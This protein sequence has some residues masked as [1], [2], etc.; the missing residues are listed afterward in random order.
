[1]FQIWRKKRFDR[2]ARSRIAVRR[3]AQIHFPKL[4]R[5]ARCV[6]GRSFRILR[7]ARFGR[8]CLGRPY[9]PKSAPMSIFRSSGASPIPADASDNSTWY[10]IFILTCKSCDI[11]ILSLIGVEMPTFL[12]AA[13]HASGMLS[14]FEQW[15]EVELGRKQIDGSVVQRIG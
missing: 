11:L 4:S 15:M 5:E 1:M 14:Q 2:F 3:N 12:P 13:S 8:D 7:V 6:M 10:R 9:S